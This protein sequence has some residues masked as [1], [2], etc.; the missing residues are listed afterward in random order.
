LA[1]MPF[2]GVQEQAE[3]ALTI[4]GKRSMILH[5]D[6]PEDL[7]TPLSYFGEWLT[8]ND[9]FFVRQHLPR[10]VMQ[11][12]DFRLSIKGRV[13]REIQL[14]PDDLKKLPQYAVT[15]VLECTGN[16]RGFFQPQVPGI[17]W[18]RG[19][20]GNAEWTGPG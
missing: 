1:L 17:Q 8:P 10:P 19:A 13:S 16:G 5:N 20:V 9:V 12:A 3:N 11:E 6:R 15:A 2:S 18:K 4:P 14:S 7:E